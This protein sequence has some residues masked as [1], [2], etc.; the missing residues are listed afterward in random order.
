MSEDQTAVVRLRDALADIRFPAGFLNDYDQL[1][2]LACGRGTETYL[3]TSR[4]SRRLFI[5]KC[6]DRNIHKTVHESS[7]LK[8][9]QHDGLPVLADEYMD[10]DMICT[11]RDYIPGTPLHQHMRDRKLSD[12]GI[13]ALGVELCDLLTYLHSQEP[14]VIH[15][16]I[17]PQ[18]V[19][20]REGGAVA[21]IDFEISRTYDS[22]AAMDTQFIGT[23]RFAPPEQYGFSQT[24]ARADIYS[25]G[26]LLCWMLTGSTDV[27]TARI[28]DARLAAIV[29]RCAA[30]S[31]EDRFP[32]AGAVK[33]ALLGVDRT[34]RRK[35]LQS[36][37]I[38]VLALLGLCAGFGLG[39]YTQLF[40]FASQP[41]G[42]RFQEPLI[43]QAVRLQLHKDAL[44]PLTADELATVKA[45]YIFGN[46]VSL[47]QDAFA[48]GLS[49][50][51]AKTQRGGIQTLEDVRL[52]PALEKMMVAYQ[53]LADIGPVAQAKYLG[54]IS[55][56][57][58]R[59]SDISPLAHMM[60]LTDVNLYDTNVSD[61]TILDTCPRMNSLDIGATLVRS[62]ER[63]GGGSSLECLS[64]DRLSFDTLDGLEHF[65]GLTSLSVKQTNIG[66]L[67]ALRA[68]PALRSV[69]LSEDMRVRASSLLDLAG[70][71]VTTE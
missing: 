34:R 39:R 61:V 43:E 18:N 7:I 69:V 37:L 64:L 33:Q 54:S 13:V 35:A 51:R 23:R 49:G 47:T 15:R 42:V 62:I 22:D 21:L 66:D 6:Y 16:D 1:E 70:I 57:H 58:T 24:D 46:E 14:P 2:C 30:F 60:S 17:K 41:Q 45:I 27:K 63:I 40:T 9:L 10:D 5:A 32:S 52:L 48:D 31:P 19:I 28:A 71:S 53:N 44:E 50:E 38:V 8:T 11:V 59:V 12:A 68:M 67:S 26:V 65:A 4:R 3:V 20:V 25:L 56:M 36:G 55:L 29:R